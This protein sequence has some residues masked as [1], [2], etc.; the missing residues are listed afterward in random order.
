MADKNTVGVVALALGLSGLAVLVYTLV[1]VHYHEASGTAAV[2][3][4]MRSI[5]AQ[6][7]TKNKCTE[8]TQFSGSGTIS[9]S[10]LLLGSIAA[11]LAAFAGV[12]A[13]P[14][15]PWV[16]PPVLPAMPSVSAMVP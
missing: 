10:V 7:A 2:E 4:R 14:A 16:T 13:S 11:I 5:I 15:D 6:K 8:S 12:L 3:S 9:Y 1:Q